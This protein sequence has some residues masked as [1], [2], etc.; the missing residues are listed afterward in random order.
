[1][2]FFRRIGDLKGWQRFGFEVAII[3]IGLSIT[4]IAQEM[5]TSAARARET[6]QATN[7]VEAEV[8]LLSL[9]ASERLAVEPCRRERIRRLGEQLASSD[10]AWVAEIP[11]DINQSSDEIVLPRIVR[12][13]IRPWSDASWSALLG[14]NAA[15]YIDRTRFSELSGIFRGVQMFREKQEDALRLS[16]RLAHLGM[17][18]PTDAAQRREAYS[19]LGEL[20]AIEGLMTVHAAQALDSIRRFDFQSPERYGRFEK[21]TEIDLQDYIAGAVRIYGDCVDISQFQPFIDDFNAV[22]GGRFAFKAAPPAP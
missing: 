11:E 19:T 20:A 9:Y 6:R 1:M 16:G 7:A 15:I 2:R 5:L 12:T 21:G 13:P 10:T 22:T 17:P 14:S 4:L 8:T 3:V 18:L